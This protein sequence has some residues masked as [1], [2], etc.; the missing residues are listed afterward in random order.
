MIYDNCLK[1]MQSYSGFPK[2]YNNEENN[3]P[4]LELTDEISSLK[5]RELEG[6][7]DIFNE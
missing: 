1:T 6:F 3:D 2:K 5:F 7:H 4:K